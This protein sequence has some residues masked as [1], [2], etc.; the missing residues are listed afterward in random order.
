MYTLPTDVAPT[1]NDLAPYIAQLS[2]SVRLMRAISASL[3]ALYKR[4]RAARLATPAKASAYCSQAD[5]SALNKAYKA[6]HDQAIAAA[7]V[8]FACGQLDAS[9]FQAV[10]R[11]LV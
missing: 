7:S 9:T 5:T 1:A 3:S 11:G 4:D 2:R 6:Q 10:L 8:L